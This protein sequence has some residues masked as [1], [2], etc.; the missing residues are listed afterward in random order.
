MPYE[1]LL[2]AGFTPWKVKIFDVETGLEDPHVTILLRRQKWRINLRTG[3]LLDK[4]PPANDLNKQVLNVVLNSL[5]ELKREWDTIHP[6][7][8]VAGND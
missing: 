6:N 3:E 5:D 1:L 7:N 8:P 4:I 2:P